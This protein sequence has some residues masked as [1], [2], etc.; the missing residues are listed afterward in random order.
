MNLKLARI[1]IGSVV[2]LTLVGVAHPTTPAAAS[3]EA[4]ATGSG[5]TTVLGENRTFAF[6]ARQFD[7]GTVKGQA[8]IQARQLDSKLHIDIDCLRVQGNTA[9]LSGT[10]VRSDNPLFEG[11]TAIF[12]VQDNGE[13]AND[14]P[15]LISLAF[16]FPPSSLTCKTSIPAPNLVV[17][18][19]NIQVRG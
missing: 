3:V 14:P 19:G 5:H 8:Q 17:E 12:T 9:V 1:L 6:T 18:R 11:Q 13:R 16:I 4:S 10:V 15:D 2:L 7:D